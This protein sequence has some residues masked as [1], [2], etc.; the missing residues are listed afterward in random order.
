MSAKDRDLTSSD[1]LSEI[2]VLFSSMEAVIRSLYDALDK[3]GPDG[4]QAYGLAMALENL[5]DQVGR[6]AGAI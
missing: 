3:F 2:C 6:Q 1:K 4:G 5:N